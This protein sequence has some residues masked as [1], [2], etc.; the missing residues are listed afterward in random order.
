[1]KQQDSLIWK[2]ILR[3]RD[4]LGQR[5]VFKLGH[6]DTS[7][8]YKDWSGTGPIANQ[9]LFV[10]ISNTNLKLRDI[11]RD[12]SWDLNRLSTMLP[13]AVQHKL[14]AVQPSLCAT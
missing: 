6:G 3:A 13:I 8:W 7:V 14:L 4:Q 11:I 1:M 5:F 12:N 9:V 2:G 10:H